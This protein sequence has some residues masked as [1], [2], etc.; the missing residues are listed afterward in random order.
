MNLFATLISWSLSTGALTYNVDGVTQ[1]ST[2]VST[3]IPHR[4]E[5]NPFPGNSCLP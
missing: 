5:L 1:T 4:A 2:V 3:T